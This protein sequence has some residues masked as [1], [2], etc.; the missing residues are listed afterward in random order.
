MQNSESK[1]RKRCE[2]GTRPLGSDGDVKL[3]C[4]LTDRNVMLQALHALLRSTRFVL[5]AL[6]LDVDLVL[7]FL[8]AFLP[9]FFVF[10]VVMNMQL[11]ISGDSMEFNISA[12]KLL[13]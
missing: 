8:L 5:Y 10:P 13:H 3:C 11:H 9:W 1:K 7:C 12:I 2:T 6:C 4:A